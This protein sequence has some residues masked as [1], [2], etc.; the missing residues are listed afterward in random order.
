MKTYQQQGTTL[1]EILISV[2]VLAIGL[3]GQAVLQTKAMQSTFD[4]SQRSQAM[5]LAQEIVERMRVNVLGV[6]RGHYT[7]AL[8]KYKSSCEH[9]AQPAKLCSDHSNTSGKS[10]GVVC[11]TEELANFDSWELLCGYDSQASSNT[12]DTISKLTSTMKC[13]D[14]DLSDS[15]PC[16]PGSDIKLKINWK[17]SFRKQK[18][19]NNIGHLELVVRP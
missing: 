17:T 8:N 18:D 7:K 3:L 10:S 11:N 2:F 16:S 6:E 14:V 13:I 9:S 15:L 4:S 1:I 19:D 5:W 12:K